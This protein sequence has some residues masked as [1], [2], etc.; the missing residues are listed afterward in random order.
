MIDKIKFKKASQKDILLYASLGESLMAV[1]ILE[2][3]LSHYIVVKK[4]EPHQKKEADILLKKQQFYTFGKAINVAKKE[5]LL[6]KHF[7]IELS[8]LLTE[9]NWLIH[10][11]IIEDKENFL[12]DSFFNRI[13]KRTETIALKARKL[14]ISIELDLI[15]YCEKKGVSM[16]KVK[17]K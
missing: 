12:S 7:E 11:S 13:I 15:E 6:P 5:S 3:A 1:Q 14:K 4:T 9:R 8:N 2:D 17:M 10:E 16:S